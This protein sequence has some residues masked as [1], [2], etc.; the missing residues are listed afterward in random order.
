MLNRIQE[1]CEE[2]VRRLGAQESSPAR[3]AALAREC[4]LKARLHDGFDERELIRFCFELTPKPTQLDSRMQYGQP[5]ITVFH[6]GSVALDFYFFVSPEGPIHDHGFAGAF[7]NLQGRSLHCT[8]RY[9]YDVT[10]TIPIYHGTLSRAAT[11]LINPGDVH[12]ILPATTPGSAFI[13]RVWHLDRPMVVAVL[14]LLHVK[15]ATIHDYYENGVALRGLNWDVPFFNKRTRLLHY[16]YETG[17]PDADRL[18]DELFRG[19]DPWLGFHY[20]FP[21]YSLILNL[22]G[23]DAAWTRI[24]EVIDILQER[25]GPFIGPAEK[26]LHA[27]DRLHAFDWMRLAKVEHRL[28]AALMHSFSHRQ[29]IDAWITRIYPGC[30]PS[31]AITRWLGEMLAD[32]ILGLTLSDEHLAALGPLIQG[33]KSAVPSEIERE[34][35]ETELFAPLLRRG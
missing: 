11:E 9:A 22:R 32:K 14:R 34:L 30:D 25:H 16:L 15:G 27:F 23:D 1:I 19:E 10:P 35:R 8:Y 20:L 18:A 24:S 5:P 3:F 17:N 31:A 12:E 13:H 21:Y 33:A 28:L 4:L 2:F 7:T 6:N 26:L 29:E